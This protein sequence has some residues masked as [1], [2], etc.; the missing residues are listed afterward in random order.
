MKRRCNADMAVDRINATGAHQGG[1]GYRL[2]AAIGVRRWR[3]G[4]PARGSSG[5]RDE[6]H[7]MSQVA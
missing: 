4:E 3:N 6:A 1:P 5:G 7:L 2:S